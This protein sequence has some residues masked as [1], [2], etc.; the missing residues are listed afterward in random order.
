MVVLRAKDITEAQVVRILVLA[1]MVVLIDSFS[2]PLDLLVDLIDFEIKILAEFLNHV[3]G[4]LLDL[5]IRRTNEMSRVVL[6]HELL[7]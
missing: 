5:L 3:K 1:D 2:Q 7:Y 6:V 4:L